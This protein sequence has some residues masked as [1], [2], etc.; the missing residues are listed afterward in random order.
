MGLS[1]NIR[2]IPMFGLGCVA[3]AA[4]ISWLQIT[5]RPP[6][7]A[8]S[9]AVSRTLLAYLAARGL[10]VAN[11]ISASLFGDGAAAVIVAGKNVSCLMLRRADSKLQGQGYWPHVLFFIPN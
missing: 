11:L 9:S 6:F 3:G 7:A 10:S 2:R 4:G 8:G 1:S 5:L